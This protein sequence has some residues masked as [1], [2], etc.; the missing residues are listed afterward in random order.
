MMNL[1]ELQR[2]IPNAFSARADVGVQTF[3]DAWLSHQPSVGDVGDWLSRAAKARYFPPFSTS[4][5]TCN[6]NLTFNRRQ[7]RSAYRL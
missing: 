3:V 7:H 5:F 4:I 2:L 1:L 6:Y